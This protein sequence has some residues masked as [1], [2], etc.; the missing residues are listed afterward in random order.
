MHSKHNHVY[1][2]TKTFLQY[3][4]PL[5][6]SSLIEWAHKLNLDATTLA[7]FFSTLYF[8]RKINRSFLLTMTVINRAGRKNLYSES[9]IALHIVKQSAYKNI[10]E[11]TDFISRKFFPR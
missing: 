3:G 5:Q 7:N 11:T 1:S 10:I 6:P 4:E 9:V 2:H 8:T